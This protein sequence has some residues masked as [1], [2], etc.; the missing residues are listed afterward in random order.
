MFAYICI[1]NYSYILHAYIIIIDF[2]MKITSV[3]TQKCINGFFL[4]NK[5]Y[6]YY[7]MLVYIK[8]R[9]DG[10]E[11]YM[12]NSLLSPSLFSLYHQNH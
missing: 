12:K 2:Y 5:L 7:K 1:Y 4:S 3:S 10:Y 11:I 6:N 9:L 8:Q